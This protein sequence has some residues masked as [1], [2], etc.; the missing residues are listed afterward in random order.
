MMPYA[1]TVLFVD[2]GNNAISRIAAT[3]PY[4]RIRGDS[5]N[6]FDRMLAGV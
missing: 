2:H 5:E 3:V 4:L 1:M 6:Y